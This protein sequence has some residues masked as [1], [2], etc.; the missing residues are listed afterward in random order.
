MNK[1]KI[2]KRVE[3]TPNDW[4]KIYEKRKGE[5]VFREEPTYLSPGKNISLIAYNF[6][7]KKVLSGLPSLKRSVVSIEVETDPA[8][9]KD[10]IVKL[11]EEI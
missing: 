7:T 8:M 4:M 2:Y 1:T 11:G 6:Q 5:L 3:V 10:Y 9:N